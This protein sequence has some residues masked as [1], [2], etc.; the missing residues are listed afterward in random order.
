[1]AS[2][3]LA[4]AGPCSPKVIVKVRTWAAFCC[5]SQTG[6][7]LA[8]IKPKA[9]LNWPK[10]AGAP[11]PL[12][13]AVPAAVPAVP[14][15]PAMPAMPAGLPAVA[16][17]P[18]GLAGMLALLSPGPNAPPAAVA[19][20]L[21]GGAVIDPNVMQALLAYAKGSNAGRQK[22]PQTQLWLDQLVIW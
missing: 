15:M 14:A 16:A 10:P 3:I 9:M 6:V 7:L 4:S 18:A 21:V 22:R 12:Q 19:E 11:V 5:P 2:S 1:M 17:V 13:L 20:S 8:H